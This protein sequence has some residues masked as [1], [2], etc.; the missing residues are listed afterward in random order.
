MLESSSNAS[1]LAEAASRGLNDSSSRGLNLKGHDSSIASDLG[2]SG[3][4]RPGNWSSQASWRRR[5]SEHEVI[6]HCRRVFDSLQN[7]PEKSELQSHVFKLEKAVQQIYTSRVEGNAKL[8]KTCSHV[9]ADLEAACTLF[10][11]ELPKHIAE[12]K[13]LGKALGTQ[14]PY[15]P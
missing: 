14:E 3:S 15:R 8:F 5:Q 12:L 9:V 6:A 1:V 10:E 7:V 13:A 4:E 2:L 11:L